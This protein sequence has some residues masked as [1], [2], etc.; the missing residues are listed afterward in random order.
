M[1]LLIRLLK[2]GLWN[3]IHNFDQQ[4]RHKLLMFES[5]CVI[6]T[7]YIPGDSFCGWNYH[8]SSFEY[9]SRC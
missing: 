4:R 6:I 5:V 3:H 8:R 7:N 1:P 9:L 2:F